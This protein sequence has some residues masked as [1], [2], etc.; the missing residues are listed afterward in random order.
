MNNPIETLIIAFAAL[1]LLALAW[2]I[3]MP[4]DYDGV[5]DREAGE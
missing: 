1:W 3:V 2:A 4:I 5:E